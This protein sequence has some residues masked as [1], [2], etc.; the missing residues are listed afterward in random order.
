MTKSKTQGLVLPACFILMVAYFCVFRLFNWDFWDGTI[1]DRALF[2][3]DFEVLENWFSETKEILNY[4]LYVFI[5]FTAKFFGV[6][7]GLVID[8]ILAVSL[9]IIFFETTEIT[10]FLTP[11]NQRAILASGFMALFF[12]FWHVLVSSI[13]VY[14]CFYIALSLWGARLIVNGKS[15]YQLVLGIFL[16]I[17]SFQLYS[18]IAA[19]MGLSILYFLHSE[20][21]S[22]SYRRA[23]MLLVFSIVSL[24]ALLVHR[25]NFPPYGLYK[26]YNAIVFPTDPTKMMRFLAHYHKFSQPIVICYG[27]FIGIF[28][29]A[30]CLNRFAK[31]TDYRKFFHT[32][33]LLLLW[34]SMA[35]L[36]YILA[37][38]S[39]LL[40]SHSYEWSQRHGFT[41]IPVIAVSFAFLGTIFKKRVQI[42]YYVIV[43]FFFGGVL[44][45]QLDITYKHMVREQ[46]IVRELSSRPPP[47]PGL[48]GLIIKRSHSSIS[49]YNL[50]W[51]AWKAWGK[52]EWLIDI[53][54]DKNS[55]VRIK[56][57][58]VRW[59]R[60]NKPVYKRK[61]VMENF[62]L[63]KSY[64]TTVIDLTD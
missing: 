40:F 23:R 26:N 31:N 29:Y 42:V 61:F 41:I 60:Q 52:K 18:N 27:F 3:G 6:T 49:F 24:V 56:Y 34:F 10:R 36:P 8:I 15:L 58:F 7:H 2:E 53:I 30:S 11:T 25:Y 35:A 37:N 44:V 28:L 50:N 55:N 21:G 48:V 51:F 59:I 22:H 47:P 5:F 62:Q 45:Y 46:E 63:R 13:F 19:I 17:I 54:E 64:T 33:I 38:K 16:L 39:P 32:T 43:L 57:V 20:K 14:H 12:P 9:G 1:I 4:Y